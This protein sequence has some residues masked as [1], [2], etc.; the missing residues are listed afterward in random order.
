MY[1]QKYR[2]SGT[3]SQQNQVAPSVL[4]SRKPATDTEI[5]QDMTAL[6]FRWNIQQEMTPAVK[7]WYN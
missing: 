4:H 2:I 5:S 1:N 3:F 6:K 7:D